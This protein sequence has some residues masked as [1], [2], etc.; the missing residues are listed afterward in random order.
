MGGGGDVEGGEGGLGGG[1]EGPGSAEFFAI[2][3]A[4]GDDAGEVDGDF[5]II[6][7]NGEVGGEGL[8]GRGGIDDW[9]GGGVWIG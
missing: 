4:E 1:G 5:A 9:R 6:G 2:F 8:T 3:G 7:F